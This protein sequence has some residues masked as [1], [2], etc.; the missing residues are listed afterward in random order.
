MERKRGGRDGEELDGEERTERKGRR[1]KDG[2]R[3]GEGRDGEK[4]M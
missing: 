3:K 4:G 2:Y 1:G